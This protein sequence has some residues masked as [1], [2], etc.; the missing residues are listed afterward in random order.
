MVRR[1]GVGR[2]VVALA[3]ASALITSLVA[4][5]PASTAAT[6]AFACTPGAA[7]APYALT[8]GVADPS[9]PSSMSPPLTNALAGYQRSYVTDFSGSTLP[10]GWSTF[11]GSPGGDPGTSWQASQ[12]VVGNG[13]LQLNA[14]YDNNLQEWVTG[15]TCVCSLPQTYGAYFVR[16]RMTGPG[17]TVVELLWPADGHTWPPEIDFN[18]TYGPAVTSMATVHFGADNSTDHRSVS[19]DMTQW[20]TW[21]VIWSP[22]AIT[23][24]VDGKVWGVVNTPGEIPTIPMTLDIQQQTWCSSGFACPTAPQSTLVDWAAIYSST[25]ATLT[26]VPSKVPA[27]T[28]IP[29][30]TSLPMNR[31]SV[32]MR[33]AALAVYHQHA[34]TVVV[35]ATTTSRHAASATAGTRVALIESML[36]HDVQI[37]G[38]K[39]PQFIVH[40]AQSNKHG[41]AWLKILLTLT[42]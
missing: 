5:A 2:L 12:V 29:V 9:E 16:S 26:P 30:D 6:R 3:S 14:A 36:T 18:E 4:V 35:S 13:V 37:F 41:K 21:G 10:S 17:P 15:G 38:A 27:V 25:A 34:R 22:S 23:Y 7:C 40:W 32:V 33:G 42:S 19:I 28:Q 11:A 20:H 24:V 39:V 31:L 8:V 1:N